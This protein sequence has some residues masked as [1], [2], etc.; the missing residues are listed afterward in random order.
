[1]GHLRRDPLA[2]V[3][4]GHVEDGGFGAV[5][6]LLRVLGQFEREDVLAVHG[7]A[8][9]DDLG[10]AGVGPGGREDLLLEAAASAVRPEHALGG[11]VH[12]GLGLGGQGVLGELD[13]LPFELLGLLVGEVDLDGRGALRGHLLAQFVAVLPGRQQQGTCPLVTSARK[14]LTSFGS[15]ELVA[16]SAAWATGAMPAPPSRSAPTAR[17]GLA[18]RLMSPLAVV[19]HSSEQ[20]PGS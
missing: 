16:L 18:L 7:L 10:E 6:G 12:A 20:M 13:A 1:M 19:R 9:G 17:I 11:L 8:D 5:L 3:L 15:G 2:R 14:T 4:V